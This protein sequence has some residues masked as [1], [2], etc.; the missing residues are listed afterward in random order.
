MSS[1]KSSHEPPPSVAPHLLDELARWPATK[2]DEQALREAAESGV[3]ENVV[4]A[5]AD[6]QGKLVGKSMPVSLFLAGELQAFSSGVLIYDNDWNIPKGFFPD[7]GYPNGF[8]DMVMKPDMRSLRML[9]HL[10]KTAVVMAEGSWPDGEPVEQLPRRI[11]ARQLERAADRGLGIVCAVETEFYVFAEDYS[12][13]RA[14]NFADLSRIGDAKGDYSIL[15]M[16]MVDP[17]VSELRRACQASGIPIEAIKH[18]WG[19]VQ[20]ELTLTYSDA[21]EAADRIALFK[22]IAKETALRHGLVAT[23]MARYSQDEGA[24]SGHIH[25]SVWDLESGRSLMA[26]ESAPDHLSAIGRNWLGGMMDLSPDLMP[27]F[28]PNVNSYKRLD[29]EAFTPVTNAWSIDV[30][31]VPFRQL[32]TGSSLH[33]ENR[34]PGADANFYLAIA[35]MVASGLDGLERKLEPIGDPITTAEIPGE[36]LPRNLPEALERFQ[37]SERVAEMLG[38][39]VVGHLAASAEQ[40]LAIFDREVSDIERRRCFESA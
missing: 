26:D 8:A 24:S 16:G 28:C 12:S 38:S 37:A 36:P 7:I 30:R 18:E 35:A 10:E 31:T 29:A 22:T 4:V 39:G 33:I 21:M 3:V 5:T 40:E 1:T 13:A 23:F 2:L 25:A 6:T 14:K 9:A 32:G 20:L 15:R 34:I 19:S 11:L 17:M 27:L